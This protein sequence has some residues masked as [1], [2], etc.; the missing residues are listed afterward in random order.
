LME[1]PVAWL[2]ET[3]G[4]ERWKT[5]IFVGIAI[6]LIGF[7]SVLSFNKFSDVELL[8]G[9]FFQS[10][11]YL[12]ANIMLPLGGLAIA[13]FT[14]WT[15]CANSTSDEVDPSVGRIYRMWRVSVKFIVPVA[16]FLI[17]LNAVGII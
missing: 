5:A 10:F 4:L 14:G 8:W 11:D 17:F 12:T 15:M 3:T 6:W 2:M 7:L 9:T 13:I 16:V 1:S